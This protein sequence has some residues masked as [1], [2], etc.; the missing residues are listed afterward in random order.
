MKVKNLLA[1][2]FSAFLQHRSDFRD[3]LCQLFQHALFSSLSFQFLL[4]TE[5]AG[6]Q[7]KMSRH[8]FINWWFGVFSDENNPVK[9]SVTNFILSY[10]LLSV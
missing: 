1:G 8:M 4:L 10:Q 5:P 9:L 3:H 7:T 6:I 2:L